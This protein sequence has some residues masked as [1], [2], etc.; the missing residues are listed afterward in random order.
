MRAPRAGFWFVAPA[1]L[2]IGL[3][4]AVPVLAALLLSTTDFDIYA[5][6]D[7]D[8]IRFVGFGNYIRL[9]QTPLFWQAFRNT[10]A[11]LFVTTNLEIGLGLLLSQLIARM[12]RGQAIMRQPGS[13]GLRG[14]RLSA[15][16]PPWRGQPWGSSSALPRGAASLARR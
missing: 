13:R 11:F 12:V 3:F 1:L 5:L 2:A 6:A 7:L 16:P 10:L 15:G 9:L 14:C 4:F 8:N